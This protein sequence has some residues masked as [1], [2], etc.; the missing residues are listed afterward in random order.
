M[1]H[2]SLLALGPP[3]ET[4]LG[5]DVEEQEAAGLEARESSGGSPGSAVGKEFWEGSVQSPSDEE[6]V[7]SDVWRR[8]FR[9]F[10]YQ[11]AEGPRDVCS[12]L[13]E[14]CRH[15]LKPD[16]FT[17]EQI[18]DLVVLEQFLSTLPREMQSWVR[19]GGA[20]TCLQ[21][22]VLAE[23]FVLKQQEVRNRD[24][25]VSTFLPVYSGGVEEACKDILFLELNCWGPF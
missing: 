13:E 7:G 20:E 9:W 16:L 17:K 8:R 18:L 11:K 21:A 23:D 5:E 25:Q 6:T 22:V 19:K 24:T 15:W 4:E 14:L 10:R 12:Q 3:L 2:K 1:A